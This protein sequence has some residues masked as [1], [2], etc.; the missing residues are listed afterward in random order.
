MYSKTG[1][2][3]EFYALERGRLAAKHF[4]NDMQKGIFEFVDEP[5]AALQRAEITK[6]RSE[7][8]KEVIRLLSHDMLEHGGEE[9]DRQKLSPDQRE[10]A[11]REHAAAPPDDAVHIADAVIP[12]A[13]ADPHPRDAHKSA[14]RE[15]YKTLDRLPHAKLDE[16]DSVIQTLDAEM[17]HLTTDAYD[18]VRTAYFDD[19]YRDDTMHEDDDAEQAM[20]FGKSKAS[21]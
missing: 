10:H 4:T 13:D 1:T 11:E 15:F 3:R 5:Y 14:H 2:T 20:Q 18:A 6:V 9:D 16:L 17:L 8:K 19:Y 12:D 21:E 7:V